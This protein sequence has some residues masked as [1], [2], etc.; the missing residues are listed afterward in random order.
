MSSMG[1]VKCEHCGHLALNVC[2][3]LGLDEHCNYC[4]LSVFISG[5]E[6]IAEYINIK[7]DEQRRNT[8]QSGE[9]SQ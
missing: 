6:I 9:N 4:G 1:K 2:D 5:E 3:E 8:Q 7:D